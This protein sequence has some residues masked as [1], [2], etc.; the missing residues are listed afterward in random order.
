MSSWTHVAAVFRFDCIQFVLPEPDWDAVTGKQ[1]YEPVD[2]SD[3][4]FAKY[5]E[6]MRDAERN[7]GSYMPFGSEGSLTR[8]VWV[9]PN[10]NMAAAY[11]VAVY[12]D[13]RDYTDVDAIRE[14][15]METCGR[16]TLRQAVCHCQCDGE[17]YTWSRSW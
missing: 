10:R 3:A 15:F 16:A 5:D 14:W 4:E 17:E 1:V 11:T 12:G 13:L 9:N 8:S 2:F 7:P 6:S